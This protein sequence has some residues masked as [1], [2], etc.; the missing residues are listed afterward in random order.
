MVEIQIDSSIQFET[1]L[2]TAVGNKKK[3][4]STPYISDSYMQPAKRRKLC[5]T[6][7]SHPTLPNL[8][9]LLALKYDLSKPLLDT[10]YQHFPVNS[11]WYPAQDRLLHIYQQ[12]HDWLDSNYP[13]LTFDHESDKRWAAVW[14]IQNTGFNI[15]LKTPA[16]W[17]L[18]PIDQHTKPWELDPYPIPE[19]MWTSL[20]DCTRHAVFGCVF[21]R[22][23]ILQFRFI[24]SNVEIK[25]TLYGKS[26]TEKYPLESAFSQ[27]QAQLI[28]LIDLYSKQ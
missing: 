7:P 1:W 18:V 20:K 25:T 28:T 9:I 2:S 24:S 12:L 10:I 13:R 27:I 23:F 4:Y 16:F 11:K 8:I 15:E 21:G 6:P 17:N 5:T 19:P 26:V 14:H 3:N 22:L